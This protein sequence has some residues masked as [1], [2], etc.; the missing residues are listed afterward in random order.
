LQFI[1]VQIQRYQ[2]DLQRPLLHLLRLFASVSYTFQAG[3]IM[4]SRPMSIVT[5]LMAR[6]AI[7]RLTQA[8][9]N[10]LGCRHH[11]ISPKAILCISREREIILR[12]GLEGAVLR[13]GAGWMGLG[14]EVV[15]GILNGRLVLEE[16]LAAET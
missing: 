4:L 1:A 13:S 11:H 14:G 12:I 15:G 3:S 8:S 6:L 9:I 16:G 2:L 5:F 7:H 10:G